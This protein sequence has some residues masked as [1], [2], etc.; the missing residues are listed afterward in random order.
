MLDVAIVGGG[1]CGL[2]L[3]VRLIERDRSVQLFDAR[4][5]LGGR[6]MTVTSQRSDLAMD[7]GPAWFWPSRQELMSRAVADL[8][9]TAFP[10][11]EDGEFLRLADPETAPERTGGERFHEGAFRLQGGMAALADALAQAIPISALHLNHALVGLRER[12]DCVQLSF[13]VGSLT[14]QWETRHVVLALPPRLVAQDVRF[15]PELDEATSEALRGAPTWMASRAKALLAYERPFWREAGL[16]G[17]ALVS[18][19]QAVLSEIF[20]A[21]EGNGRDAALGGF[22][23]LSAQQRESFSV[24]LLLLM[25]SQ[26]VQLFGQSAGTPELQF[27]DWAREPLTCSALDRE[28]PVE[29]RADTANPL[30]RRAAW[31]GKLHFGGAETAARHAGLLEGALDAARRIERDLVRQWV[32]PQERS[33]VKPPEPADVNMAS[34]ARFEAWVAGEADAAFDDYRRRLHAGLAVQQREQLTQRALLGAMESLFA[35]ALGELETLNFSAVG[36]TIEHG[37]SSLTPRVQEAFRTLMQATVDD[38]IAFNR[39]SCAL[40]NF[41]DEHRPSKPYLQVILRDIAAAWQEFSLSANRLLLVKAVE[42]RT[43]AA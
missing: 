22:L 10:Q 8:R 40:S 3:A 28:G 39:T 41:P 15:E 14:I 36:V 16:S 42:S 32:N 20:D 1:L 23:A 7:L 31:G 6:I 18:H 13:A 12:A 5:R 27:Q 35:R 21:C 26:A 38:V 29:E 37:R 30:L 11:S 17:G 9:L 24:G 33:G 34:L 19:E 4:G 43:D 25:E 2:E